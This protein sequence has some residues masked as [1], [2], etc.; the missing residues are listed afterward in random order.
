MFAHIGNTFDYILYLILL[1]SLC[2]ATTAADSHESHPEELC[3]LS[4][5]QK[6]AVVEAFHQG[7]SWIKAIKV[8][9][10]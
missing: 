10:H 6:L 7:K 3:S 1:Q 4:Q 8:A 9:F 5:T 2:Q